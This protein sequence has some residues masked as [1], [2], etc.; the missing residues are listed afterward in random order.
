[1]HQKFLTLLFADFIAYLHLSCTDL[2]CIDLS[3]TDLSC[4]DLSCTDLSCTDLSC[5]DP[6]CTDLS[7]TDFR[8]MSGNPLQVSIECVLD[9]PCSIM[10]F[11]LSMSSSG[12]YVHKFTWVYTC[13]TLKPQRHSHTHVIHAC[14]LMLGLL[15]PF[16]DRYLAALV[17]AGDYSTDET[18]HSGI[19]THTHV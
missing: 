3:C 14:I 16:C 1:M 7:C 18:N 2:S 8:N 12:M 9:V 19:H 10:R 4:T 6:S 13:L 15:Q 17:S 5:A 11:V